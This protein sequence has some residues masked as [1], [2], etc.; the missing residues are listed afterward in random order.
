[1]TTFLTFTVIGLTAGAV[2][3]VIASGLVVTYATTGI[4]NFAHGATGMLGAFAYWQLRE[5]WGW[6]AWL[7]VV[8]VIGGAAPAVGLAMERLVRGLDGTSEATRLVVSVSVLVGMLGLAQAIWDPGGA[9]SVAP[10]FRSTSIELA[11]TRISG[12]QIVTVLVAVAVAIALRVL[13]RGTRAG[14]SMRAVVD[15]RALG[16]LNGIETVRAQQ[17]GWVLGTMLAATGGILVAS[18]AGLNA[19]V[20]SSLIVN[21]YAA[22]IFGRLRSLPLTF[23][24]ALV[25][26]LVDGYLQGYLPQ[27]ESLA[28]LRLASPMIVLFVALLVIPSPRLRGH[29]ATREHYPAPTVAGLATFAGIVFAAGVVLA[30]TLSDADAVTYGKIF[31]TAVIGLSLVPLLGY[32]NQLS[33]CQLSL[34]GIGAVTYA[35]LG[36]GGNPLGLVAAVVVAAAVGSLVALPALRL[37]G[38][39]LALATAAFAVALDRWIFFLPDLDVGPVTISLFGQ[40]VLTVDPLEAGGLRFDDARTQIVLAA[41]LFAVLAV[42]VG[43]VRRGRFGRR[44]LAQRDSEA[45]C[46]TFGMGLV[47]TRLAVFAGSAGIAGLGGALLG[48]QVGSIQ[49]EA[50]SFTN[51][52]PLFMAVAAGGAGFVSAALGAGVFLQG[53]FPFTSTVAPWFTR[54]Q[55][56]TIGT[57]GLTLGRSPSGTTPLWR[58]GFRNLVADRPVHAGMLAAMVAAWALRLFGAYGNWPFVAILVAL[59]LGATGWADVRA[60]RA[61]GSPSWTPAEGGDR[62]TDGREVGWVDVGRTEADAA[63]AL[64]E[65]DQPD[66]VERVEREPAVAT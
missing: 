17:T 32:G 3:A 51:G 1:M 4:F 8:A 6:P 7:A 42:A 47:G 48:M 28:G 39:H 40:G 53:F 62:R 2:Y 63:L 22:A 23:V 10:F 41:G 21:A 14:V 36:D 25:V 12:H 43:L 37:S 16:R 26:G 54:W 34:A 11:S 18:T 31:P 61:G 49:P 50:F 57:L 9:R 65:F 46:A 35:H 5:A 66:T 44:L 58:H 30:T 29:V 45:A 33:L 59:L 38:I 52:L 13:L 60:V 24:G 20:L 55:P 27:S 64:A 15:D 19:V 56:L